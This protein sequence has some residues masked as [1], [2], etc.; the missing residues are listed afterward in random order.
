MIDLKTVRRDIDAASEKLRTRLGARG[1]TL[2]QRLKRAGRALPKPA[3]QAGWRLVELEKLLANPRLRRLVS[4][5][6][7]DT[8]LADL[9]VHLDKVN[10]SERRKDRLLG[11]VGSAVGNLLLLGVLVIILLRWRGL[12]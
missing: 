10:P 11:F 12:V 8:A 7:L 6:E 2:T 9:N 4:R 1:R 3:R 5:P